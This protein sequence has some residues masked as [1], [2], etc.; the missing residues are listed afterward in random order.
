MKKK[1]QQF[2][3]RLFGIKTETKTIIKHTILDRNFT[4]EEYK[5][6]SDFFQTKAGIQFANYLLAQKYVVADRAS[7]RINNSSLWH[8]YVLGYKT[9]IEHILDFR[10]SDAN[11][12]T[13]SD[14]GEVG[15]EEL[16]QALDDHQ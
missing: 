7:T 12:T 1:I 3:A 14:S 8:G 6:I 16:A 5:Y 4:E 13:S 10:Q 15:L 11:D 9:A 2:I